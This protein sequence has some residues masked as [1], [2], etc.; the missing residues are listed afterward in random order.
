[1][2][3]HTELFLSKYFTQKQLISLLEGIH[4]MPPSPLGSVSGQT[5]VT[6]SR[7]PA[8]LHRASQNRQPS[9]LQLCSWATVCLTIFLI[10]N[11]NDKCT[12]WSTCN[13]DG[14]LS[15]NND[16]AWFTDTEGKGAPGGVMQ[17]ALPT[18]PHSWATLLLPE[19]LPLS[20]RPVYATIFPVLLSLTLK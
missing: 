2:V 1:M 12:H 4:L 5:A 19:A 15:A 10:K 8:A 7:G 13:L 9:W 18:A 11:L 3:P 6:E 20:H 16:D 17:A 14:S